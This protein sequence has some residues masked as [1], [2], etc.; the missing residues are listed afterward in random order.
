MKV[1]PAELEILPKSK[2][3]QSKQAKIVIVMNKQA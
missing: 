1:F 2:E 3:N